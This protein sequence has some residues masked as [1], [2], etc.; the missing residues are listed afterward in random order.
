MAKLFESLLPNLLD[1]SA[2]GLFF[3][4]IPMNKIASLKKL[5]YIFQENEE[6]S[7][8]ACW[9]GYKDLLNAIPHHDYDTSWILSFFYEEI[10]TQI[11]Q[12][13]N[14]MCNGQFMHKSPEEA[15]DFF[16]ELVE[17]NQSWDFSYSFNNSR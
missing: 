6:E 4:K 17:N 11:G 1:M 8:Y 14:M 7:F 13:I 12:F 3:K 16:D 15:L 2:R 10:S 9:E 5:I